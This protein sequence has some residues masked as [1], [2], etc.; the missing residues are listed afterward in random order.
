MV[1]ASGISSSCEIQW[2]CC[3]DANAFGGSRMI[4]DCVIIDKMQ[5][6]GYQES[7]MRR[8]NRLTANCKKCNNQEKFTN[9]VQWVRLWSS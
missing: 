8:T 1:R 6:I 3:L 7:R 5:S 4:T 9:D 2:S